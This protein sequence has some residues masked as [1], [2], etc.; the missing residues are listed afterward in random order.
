M[1]LLLTRVTQ[2]PGLIRLPSW[3]MHGRCSPGLIEVAKLMDGLDI[4]LTMGV[5]PGSQ[6]PGYGA[7]CF[8]L[9]DVLPGSGL[10]Y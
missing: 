10:P 5:L 3:C 8:L 1:S 4:M 7:T 2:K 9:T 6:V